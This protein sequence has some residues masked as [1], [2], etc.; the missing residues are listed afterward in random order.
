MKK[1]IVKI[2][3]SAESW[4][5][6]SAKFLGLIL[7]VEKILLEAVKISE[8]ENENL[9]KNFQ[10]LNYQDSD[11]TKFIVRTHDSEHG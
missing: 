8:N 9:W 4:L 6:I 3:I 2:E 5:K 11:G 7:T 1:L 10:I